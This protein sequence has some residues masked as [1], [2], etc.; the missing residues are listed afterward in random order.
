ME[1]LLSRLIGYVAE[2]MPELS[3]V[4]EDYGQ[5]ANLDKED[6]DMYPLT[7]PAVLIE[8]S[9]VRWEYLRGKHQKGEATL[10]VRLIVDC[11]DDTHAES[12]TTYRIMERE[13]LRHRLHSLLQGYRPLEDGQLMRTQSSFFTFNH[14]IKVYES[15]YTCTVT[16][17]IEGRGVSIGTPPQL[18]LS[19]GVLGQP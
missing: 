2:N 4:D 10:R 18:L 11:Y 6:E 16:E 12:G 1:Y 9:E 7:F 17:L 19:M 3:L 15:T 13:L 14:G 5:L 8:P